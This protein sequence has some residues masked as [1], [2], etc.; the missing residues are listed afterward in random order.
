MRY[1]KIFED[2]K[3][4]KEVKPKKLNMAFSI[5]D[6]DVEELIDFLKDEYKNKLPKL[7]LD[8]YLEKQEK[9]AIRILKNPFSFDNNGVLNGIENFPDKIT[10]YRIVDNETV[11]TDCLGK[12]WTYDRKWVKSEEF[13]NSVGFESGNKWWVIEA[14]FKKENIDPIETLE[15]LIRNVTEKEIRLKDKCIKPIEYKITEYE[16]FE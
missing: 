6:I 3:K 1:L 5:T 2:F 14:T 8:E 13:Q 4:D 10:L 15:M 11:K 9:E 12:Y 16:N 7:A